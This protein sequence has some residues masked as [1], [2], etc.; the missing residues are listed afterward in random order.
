MSTPPTDGK[1]EPIPVGAS[2]SAYPNARPL[3]PDPVAAT[4]GTTM[5]SVVQHTYGEPDVLK[6]EVAARP[7]PA[8]G[9]VR[10]RVTASSVNARGGRVGRL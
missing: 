5:R 8:A 9:E 1:T 2:T 10:V 4:S 7:A 3:G 6:A